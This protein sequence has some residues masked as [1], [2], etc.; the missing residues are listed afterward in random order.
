[1]RRYEDRRP[2]S[3]M[4]PYLVTMLLVCD[5][6]QLPLPSCA[7]PGCPGAAGN[8]AASSAVR[9]MPSVFVLAYRFLGS[10]RTAMSSWLVHAAWAPCILL[11]VSGQHG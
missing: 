5:A 8:A 1:M 2:A 3:N 11:R 6:L 9:V 4:D 7:N 10:G